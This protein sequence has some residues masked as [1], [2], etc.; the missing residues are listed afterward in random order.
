MENL[1][2]LNFSLVKEEDKLVLKG[3]KQK[4]TEEDRVLSIKNNQRDH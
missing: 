2:K 1:E 3:K 4:V